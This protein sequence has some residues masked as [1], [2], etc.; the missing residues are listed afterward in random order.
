[1]PAEEDNVFATLG[2]LGERILPTPGCVDNIHICFGQIAY[3]GQFAGAPDTGRRQKLHGKV[4]LV[5]H[6]AKLSPDAQQF[7]LGVLL[8]L[9]ATPTAPTGLM[10]PF[11]GA[12]NKNRLNH[13]RAA[14]RSCLVL[15]FGGRDIRPGQPGQGHS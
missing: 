15:A 14:F 3:S 1:M 9:D 4:R 6:I 8:R 10:P 12:V 7:L 13:K 2:Q 11:G 5:L